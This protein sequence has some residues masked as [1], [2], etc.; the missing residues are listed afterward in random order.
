MSDDRGKRRMLTGLVISDKMQKTI[1]VKVERFVKHPIIK[2]Y[3]KKYTIC[4]AHDE[5]EEAQNGDQVEIMETRPMSKTKRWRLV[6]ILKK[7][8]TGDASGKEQA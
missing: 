5:K 6:R 7:Q 8:E 1:T 4:K 2:K 3:I